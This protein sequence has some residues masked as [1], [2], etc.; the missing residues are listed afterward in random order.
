MVHV[1]M[2]GLKKNTAQR[3]FSHQILTKEPGIGTNYT[4][5][6]N[7]AM[8]NGPFEDVSPIKSGGF[9]LLC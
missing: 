4:P 5:E 3:K 9:S 7:I 1:T 6:S 2:V 8:E